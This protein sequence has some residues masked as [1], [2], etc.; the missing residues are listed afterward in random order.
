MILTPF[1]PYGRRCSD[2]GSLKK[3]RRRIELG[4]ECGPGL[5][6]RRR[7]RLGAVQPAGFAP[8]GLVSVIP[9]KFPARQLSESNPLNGVPICRTH[10]GGCSFDPP[11]PLAL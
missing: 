5:M 11:Q 1:C 9:S 4:M 8:I 2:G 7:R 6:D 10:P 3:R